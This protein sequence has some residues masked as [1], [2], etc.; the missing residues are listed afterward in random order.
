MPD[1]RLVIPAVALWVCCGVGIGVSGAM[2]VVAVCAGVLATTALVVAAAA[3]RHERGARRS[4]RLA[5]AAVALAAVALGAV[6]V[7]AQAPQR[8]DPVLETAAKQKHRVEVAVRVESAPQR[9]AA[10]FDGVEHWRLRGT[11][12]VPGPAG[13]RPQMAGRGD[14]RTL[15]GGGVPVSIVVPGDARSARSYA[16]GAVITAQASVLVNEPGE[17]TSYRLRAP[18]APVVRDAPPPWLAWAAPVRDAFARAASSTPGDGGDLLPGLAIG[19][20]TAVGPGLDEAMK[21][22]ALSHLT[23]VSGANCALVTGLVFLLARTVGLGRRTRI[24]AAA[25]AL[26]AFVALVGPGASVLRAAAMATVVLLG[27]A[28]GR[29]ADGLPALALA[30]VVL[31]VHD[32]WLARDYGFALSA[33]ATAGLLLLARPLTAALSQWLPRGIALALAVPLSA[34]LACQPVLILLTPT[35][36]LFGVPANL[37]AE[38]AAPVAT[39]LGCIACL[40]LPWAPALGQ[41]LVWLAWLPSAWIALVARFAADLPGAALPWP[42][43]VLGVLLCAL[44]LVAVA[45]LTVRRR[46]PRVLASSATIALVGGATL[47]AGALGGSEVGRAVSMPGDWR[48]AACDVGQGDALLLRDGD[49]V[50]LIDV[51]RKPEPLARCL[52]MLGV[53]RLDWVLLTHFDADHAGGVA[54]VLGRTARAIVGQ[55]DRPADERYL[56]RLRTAGIGIETGRAGMSGVLGSTPWQIVWPPAAVPGGTQLSGNP[57]SLVVRTEGRGLSA[58]FLGDLGAGE[59]DALQASGSIGPVDVVKVSHHGSADQSALFYQKLRARLGLVS[60][61]DDNG[62]GHPTARALSL[63]RE[64]GTVAA[65]TD[66]SGMLLVSSAPGGP[67]LWTERPDEEGTVEE[68]TDEEGTGERSPGA[69]SA[70]GRPYPGYGRGGTWRHEATAG[71]VALEA[72]RARAARRARSLSWPGTRSGP[73]RSSWCRARRASSPIAP[74]G[75]CATSSSRTTRVSRSA[76]CPPPTTPRASCSRSRAPPCSASRA[77][78]GSMRSRRPVTASWPTCSTTSPPRPR[79]PSWCCATPVAFA[80][81]SCSTPS[82]RARAEASRSSAPN[83]RRTPRSTTSLRRSSPPRV[84]RSRPGLCGRSPPRS[85]TTS[86]SSPRRV[87]SCSPIRRSRSPRRPSTSITGAGSRRTRSRSPTRPSRAVTARRW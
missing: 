80:A 12:V 14:P 76:T 48:I 87:S 21:V 45:L 9:S 49:H 50:A 67:A 65:R 17:K 11:T 40:L 4:R 55:P 37:V 46:L 25:A 61:G 16:L 29:V 2:P 52:E 15:V 60:V 85:R 43:G 47:Y 77:S 72:A 38:P 32:P 13:A 51:G 23:A 66:R 59:Q 26:A 24:V 71:A 31:L 1:L 30:V 6:A 18:Q 7:G 54:A 62:Y 36:P 44:T 69:E 28:R 53:D 73:R 82:A 70:G 3:G 57:G 42:D 34:Q 22:S 75:C 5:A 58:L 8:T 35:L 84:A 64:S 20:E 56:E 10:G 74:R 86:P 41:L 63:L 78:S 19:D 27:L 68:G 33:L 81:R 39:V 79:A 83:S